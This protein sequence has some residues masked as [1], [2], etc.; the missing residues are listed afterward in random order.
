M[1]KFELVAAV[2]KEIG[3]TQDSVNKVIDSMSNVIVR[4]CVENGS[5]SI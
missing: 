1:K 5:E 2:A 4:E 3:L